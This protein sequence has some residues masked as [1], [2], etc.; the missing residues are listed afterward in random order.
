M[1]LIIAEKPSIDYLLTAALSAH[2]KRDGCLVGGGYIVSWC[3][4]HQVG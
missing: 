2:E 4:D 3:I 1:Q